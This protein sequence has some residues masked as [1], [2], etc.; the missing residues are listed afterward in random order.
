[1]TLPPIRPIRRLSALLLL[2]AAGLAPLPVR[3]AA[4]PAAP[5]ADPVYDEYASGPLALK[6]IE[7]AAVAKDRRIL[8]N[9]GTNDCAPCATF[10]AALHESRAFEDAL[11]EQ[12]FIVWIDVS[13]GSENEKLLKAC[14]LYTS[15]SPRD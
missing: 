4:P 9:F 13:P 11:K 12:F 5:Q 15:P 2:A 3:A 7:P 10:A 1:M 6:A 14:L 8:V